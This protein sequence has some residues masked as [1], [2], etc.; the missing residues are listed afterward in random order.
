MLENK[1]LANTCENIGLINLCYPNQPM[2]SS[3]QVY[4]VSHV[5]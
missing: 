2:L 4:D 5:T 3:L 1:I